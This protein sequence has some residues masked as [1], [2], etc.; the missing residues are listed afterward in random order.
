MNNVDSMPPGPQRVIRR[1]LGPSLSVI[2]EDLEIQWWESEMT[3]IRNRVSRMPLY[4]RKPAFWGLV[5]AI[6]ILAFGVIRGIRNEVAV[7]AKV[8]SLQSRMVSQK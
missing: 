3:K 7:Q 5:F 2:R 4:L 6:A 1:D 8:M